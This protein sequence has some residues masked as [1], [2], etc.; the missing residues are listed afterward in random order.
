MKDSLVMKIVDLKFKIVI[1]NVI[2]KAVNKISVYYIK[3]K[4]LKLI[5]FI[6]TF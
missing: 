6:F 4:N 1:L 5:I 3:N 2:D